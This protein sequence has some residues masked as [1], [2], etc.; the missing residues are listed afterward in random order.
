[1][2]RTRSEVRSLPRKGIPRPP[3]FLAENADK[4]AKAKKSSLSLNLKECFGLY[5]RKLFQATRPRKSSRR[6][7]RFPLDICGPNSN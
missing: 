4:G 2:M 1:M 7:L 5:F 6:S 3:G